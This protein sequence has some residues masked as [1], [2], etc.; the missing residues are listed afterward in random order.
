[1]MDFDAGYQAAH[2][3]HQRNQ[4]LVEWGELLCQDSKE[5]KG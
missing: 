5:Q 2:M 4:K 3:M 1:M